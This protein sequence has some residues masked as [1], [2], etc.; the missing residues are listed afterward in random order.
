MSNNVLSS[1]Q[2]KVIQEEGGIKYVHKTDTK[3]V[4]QMLTKLMKGVGGV[5][6]ILTMADK[7]GGWVE[8]MLTMATNGGGKVWNPPFLADIICEQSLK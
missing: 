3:K 5:G 1:N 2:K 6:E 4:L 8:E 7:R